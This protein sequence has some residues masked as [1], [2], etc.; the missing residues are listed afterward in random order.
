MITT[1]FFPNQTHNKQE[2]NDSNLL[3]SLNFNANNIDWQKIN[4]EFA[5]TDWNE[6]LNLNDIDSSTASLLNLLE[7]VCSKYVPRKLDRKR[8]EIPRDRKN[9]MRKRKRLRS[10]LIQNQNLTRLE[11]IERQLIEIEANLVNSHEMESKRLEEQ[12]V[13]K[14]K[15]NPKVF[16]KYVRSKSHV[17][18]PVGPLKHKDSTV[19]D[20]KIMSEVL[21]D[22]FESVFS[23]PNETLDMNKLLKDIGPRSLEDIE[24]TEDD[25]EARIMEISPNSSPGID[26]VAA[27]LLRNC[28]STLKKPIYMLWRQS[29]TSGKFPTCMKLGLVIPVFKGGNR[30]LA[31]NYRPISLTSHISKLFERIVVRAL[32]AYLNSANLFN[33]NQHGFRSGR[34]CLSQLLE[35]HQEVLSA[36]ESKAAVDVVYLDFAKAFDRVDYSI[37]LGKLKSIGVCSS[38][39][40]WLGS[41]LTGRRQCVKVGPRT[42][43]E[44]PVHSGVPQG[45]ALGPLLFLILIADIDS[46]VKYVRVSS[47]ADDTRFLKTIAEECDCTKM[48]DDLIGV[49]Q[50]AEQNNMAFNNK[51]FQLV[52]YSAPTRNLENINETYGLFNYPQYYDSLGNIIQSTQHIKD[53][54]VFITSDA[55]FHH[56]IAE[57]VRTGSRYAGWV[58]RSFKTRSPGRTCASYTLF[59]VY[60]LNTRCH[61]PVEI[62][63]F[64][65]VRCDRAAMLGL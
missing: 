26:G 24:F 57:S 40:K 1:C 37:L 17:K 23:I 47:F 4:T 9:L 6:V 30:C 13:E 48:Q 27:L 56:Q 11:N 2:L 32:T 29:L 14:I 10:K 62:W 3:S 20:P 43:S 34:S 31:E 46:C 38:L 21:K 42:S 53:L 64:A 15:E 44:G 61:C 58:L 55:K 65:V 8:S 18:T 52:S 35:H 60:I 33:C 36:I 49:Y 12:A 28:A 16:Y 63:K 41:F 45:S 19:T 51:K 39:L 59:C 50:W 25:I 7:S 5:E 54:G 22:H